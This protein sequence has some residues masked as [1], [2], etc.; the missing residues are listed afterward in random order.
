MFLFQVIGILFAHRSDGDKLFYIQNKGQWDA[1]ILYKSSIKNGAIFLEQ[2][3]ITINVTEHKSHRFENEEAATKPSKGHAYYIE[4]LGANKNPKIIA[5]KKIDEYFNYYLGDD[6]IKWQSG[7]QG[8]IDIRYQNIYPQIDLVISS[9][10]LQPKYTFY[11]KKGA[12]VSDIQ[13]RFEGLTDMYLNEKG[14]IVSVTALGNVTDEKPISFM[15]DEGKI[16]PVESWFEL[17]NKTI[18]FKVK[19][20]EWKENEVLEIDPQI[21][22]STYSGSVSDNFGATATYDFAGNLYGAGLVFGAL[23]PTTTG[24]Y[25]T[26]YGD[27]SDIGITKFNATGSARI[28]S[29]YI[30][31]SS[32]DVPHSLVVDQNNR[33]I[34]LATTSSSNY[35]TTTGAYDTVFSG[36]PPLSL[37]SGIGVR[38][39]AGADIAI[40]KFNPAGTTLVGSTFFGGSGTDGV[41]SSTDLVKNYGD[42]IRGEVETDTLGNIYIASLSTS[43]N[44]A[45]LPNSYKS[46]NSGGY[47]GILAKFNTN[48]TGLLAFTYIGGSGN[49]ALYDLCFDNAGNI[50]AAGGTNSSNLAVSSNAV[51]TSYGGN[52]DGMVVSLTNNLSNLRFSSYYGTT[53]YD[54]VYF[55]ETDKSNQIYLFGQTTHSSSSYYLLNATY[56]NPHKGQFISVL[57]PN[58]SAKVRTTMFGAGNQNPDISPT[59]FLVDYCDK[60]FITGW[61]TSNM[62]STNVFNLSTTGLNITSNAF[63]STTMGSGFYMSILEGDLSAQHYGSFF[64]GTTSVSNE[65]VD[66]GTS[67]FDKNGIV[68]HAVCA[69]CGGNQNFPIRPNAASVVGPTNNSFNCNLGVFKFDFGLPVT[70]DFSYTPACAPAN[71]KFS[72]FSHTVSS[73]ATHYWSFSS[74]QT[75]TLKEPTITFPNA[76]VY[77]ARLVV[78]DSAS[79]NIADTLIK[80]IIILGTAADTLSDK[81]ICIGSSTRVG[82]TNIIDTGLVF[83]WS[84][85]ATLDDTSILSPFASPISTTKYRLIISKNGCIDTFYQTVVIDSPKTIVIKGDSIVCTGFNSKFECTNF[86]NGSYEW[87]PKNTLIFSNRDTAVYNFISLPDTITVNYTNQ[88]GCVS[89]ARKSLIQTQP[90]LNTTADSIV[91]K[92]DVITL[93]TNSNIKGGTYTFLPN[94]LN[95]LSSNADSSRIQIDTSVEIITTY[96]ISAACTAKDTIRIKLLKDQL[97]WQIDSTICPNDT[98]KAIANMHSSYT[99]VWNPAL[100]LMTPQGQSPAKF[101]LSNNSQKIYIQATHNQKSYCKFNDSALVKFLKVSVKLQADT[102]KCKDSLVTIYHGSSSGS[103][104]QWQPLSLLVS[105]TNTNATFRVPSSGLYT[106][107]ITDSSCVVKDSIYIKTLNDW[108]NIVGDSIVCTTDSAKIEVTKI[109]GATYRW[110]PFPPIL[111]KADSSTIFVKP[112]APQ[113]FY[114]YVQDTNNCFVIDSFFVNHLDSSNLVQADFSAITQCQNLAVQFKNTSSVVSASP[115]YLWKFSSFGTSSAFN[116]SFNFPSYGLQNVTLIVDDAQT[117]NKVDSIT[118]PIYIMNNQRIILPTIKN[119]KGDSVE[120]GLESMNDTGATIRWIP[121]T[122]MRDT[123][124]FHPTVRV[125]DSTTF[126]AYISKGG[127]TDT[128]I[129]IVLTDTAK[130]IG[131]SGENVICNFSEKLY[132]AT[133]YD[134]GS[135]QWEPFNK[136]SYQDRDTASFLINSNTWIKANYVSEYGC[137]SRDSLLVTTING[138]LTLQMDSIGCK[139]EVLNMN[140]MG[141]PSGGKITI[142]PASNVLSQTISFA[143]FKVDTTQIISVEYKLNNACL[144]RKQIS[145]KLLK[146]AVNWEYDSVICKNQFIQATAN[147]SPNWTL[148]WTPTNILQTV[149]GQ[150]PAR[151]GPIVGTQ[152]IYIEA[153]YKPRPTC[154]YLDSTTIQ[155]F[156]DAVKIMGDSSNCKDSFITLSATYFPNTT[157]TW[158]PS[159]ALFNSNGNNAVFKTDVSRTYYVVARNS[160]GCTS[161]DSHFVFAGNPNFKLWGDTVVCLNDTVTL[162][163]SNLPKATY[164]WSNGATSTNILVSVTQPRTYILD[165]VDS[166]NC[167]LKDSIR[168]NVFDGSFLKF[169]SNDSIVCKFDTVKLEVQNLAKVNYQWTPSQPILSGQ[170]TNKIRAWINK[171]TQFNLLATLVRGTTTCQVPLTIN[172]IKD[173]NYIQI[174]S[175]RLVC[176]M[177]TLTLTANP[178]LSSYQYQWLPTN[179]VSMNRNVVSYQISDSM[180]VICEVKNTINNKCKYRD[181]VKVDYSRYLDGLFVTA[182][183]DRVEFGS[184]TVLFATANNVVGYEWSPSVNLS[185]KYVPSPTAKP[186]EKTTYHVTVRDPLGCR[187]SDSVIVD[188]YFEICDEP[189]IYVP[190]GFTPNKDAKNDALFVMGDNIEKMHFMIYDRWGQLI[191]ESKHQKKGWDGTF[192]GVELEP[193][194]FAYYL[195]V[196]CTGGATYTKKGNITLIK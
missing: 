66:G 32:Y 6:P 128:M 60:I 159:S 28:F 11:L 89:T 114:V 18:S 91:C 192:N 116:P 107:T 117:C 14:D 157:Y 50:V 57:S 29:T 171:N 49:D 187:A 148:D 105:Q 177:D 85:T 56:S 168:V 163:A 63:Q 133:K 87:F 74:G 59:A 120:I 1:K 97:Q 108:I 19:L 179:W 188:V 78:V 136:V 106:L 139:D 47:D 122:G 41:G 172:M 39:S 166:N 119:C 175:N 103:I 141:A 62:G 176:K 155:I 17:K 5:E 145:F 165:V 26:T 36:G 90:T 48:L 129:Q 3:R 40:T 182:T 46:T 79:C 164:L 158:G 152:K 151:F 65:H 162:F 147:I 69:G 33:L 58:M 71:I 9:Q 98:A 44:I 70:A 23:Y 113:W 183:P 137:I 143:Q 94:N 51:N 193:A 77:T 84:P 92:G 75:S 73:G 146:D 126:T 169:S 81:V 150:S 35:P 156:E 61:G 138:S 185:N 68:Y 124:S 127:C 140:Y 153:E 184:T 112:S 13:M 54:Q 154:T 37:M 180:L 109:G 102:I 2:D 170:G 161:V 22:F 16:Q 191:F 53:D 142:L 4:F 134:S 72:N 82:F 55:V 80:T 118:K 115:T 190:T 96:T 15:H 181:S 195:Y 130:P 173:T 144:D 196:E 95:I 189:E 12:K 67:R 10:S 27:S 178:N 25:Q 110:T 167:K 111:T 42:N 8:F 31:G 86:S 131:I 24:A 101:N 43:N 121:N 64:G 30:G 99:I 93:Y 20:D 38:Y 194:V 34:L 186:N 160:L 83:S 52:T 135:Y 125:F 132:I 21:I 45:S 7:C 104:K 174:D 149:Q 76:G 88:Y 123:S 100:T